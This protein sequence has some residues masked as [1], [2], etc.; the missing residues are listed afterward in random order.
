MNCPESKKHKIIMIED[1][2]VY[3]GVSYIF[4]CD[5][6]KLYSRWDNSDITDDYQEIINKLI[7]YFDEI[8]EILKNKI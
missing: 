4:C 6:K 1:P 8:V 3:D 7:T 5:C 2:M